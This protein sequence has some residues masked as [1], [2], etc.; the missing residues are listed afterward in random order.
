MSP[1]N[2]A[3]LRR[4][5]QT[6]REVRAESGSAYRATAHLARFVARKVV[7]LLR[8]GSFTFARLFLIGYLRRSNQQTTARPTLGVRV[9]GG[10]GD[11]IV[12]ARFLRDL[13]TEAG[14]FLLDV[15]SNKPRQA[16]WLFRSVPNLRNCYDEALFA[17][18]QARYTVAAQI[19][20]FILIEDEWLVPALHAKHPALH[21]AVAAIRQ[22]RPSIEPIVAEHPR[23]DSFL[24][25]K[26]VF[27]N[28][29]RRDYLHLM[30]GIPYA[31]DLFSIDVSEMARAAHHLDN[32]TYVTVHNGYDPNMVVSH[33][34]ATKCYPY[35]QEVVGLL[36]QRHPEILFVQLGIHTSQPIDGVDVNLIGRTTLVEAAGII[37]GALFHLDNEGGLVHIASALGTRSAV[38]FGPTSA[39]YFGYPT[40]INIEPSFCGGCWWITETWMNHCP[41]GFPTARCMAEQPAAVVALAA[42]GLFPAEAAPVNANVSAGTAC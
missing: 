1:L 32:R 15:Y 9:L 2:R 42:E 3:R 31:G 30:A 41:R 23:L 19:S 11:Y 28:R 22:F 16:A 34:R 33:E 12:I 40:N 5:L 29:S 7:P 21:R 36:R 25:Q 27:A 26:A 38:V 14:P 6:Y 8:Y 35:F 24:A 20:Q 18:V 37:Q 39:L 4:L 13:Q 17:P 10:V